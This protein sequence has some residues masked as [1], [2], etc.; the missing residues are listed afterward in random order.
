MVNVYMFSLLAVSVYVREKR[1]VGCG[2]LG[3]EV[4]P[5]GKQSAGNPLCFAEC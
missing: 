4:H 1:E 2:K 5:R 3:A